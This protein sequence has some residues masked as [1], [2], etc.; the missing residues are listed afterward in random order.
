MAEL[1][2]RLADALHEVRLGADA[3]GR[4]PADIVRCA[5]RAAYGRGYVDAMRATGGEPADGWRAAY[6]AN[7]AL[8]SVIA[9]KKASE[10]RIPVVR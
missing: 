6:S 2:H 5:L 8:A 3:D 10:I 7:L 9:R 4:V 1:D